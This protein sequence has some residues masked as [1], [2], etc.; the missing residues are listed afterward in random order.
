MTEISPATY[1]YSLEVQPAPGSEGQYLWIIRRNGKVY[2]RADRRYPS[3]EKATKDGLDV[4][5]RLLGPGGD[6]F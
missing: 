1:P 4:I 6:R 2:Q 3:E 5:E